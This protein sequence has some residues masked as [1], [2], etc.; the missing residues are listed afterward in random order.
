[1]GVELE[2]GHGPWESPESGTF[3]GQQRYAWY[4]SQAALARM[5][6]RRMLG[7]RCGFDSELVAAELVSNAIRHTVSG[8]R[9]GHFVVYVMLGRTPGIA[10]QDLGGSGAPRVGMRQ[11]GRFSEGGR[12]L[13]LVTRLAVRSGYWGDEREGHTVWAELRSLPFSEPMA[14]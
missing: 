12:G 1:M 13:E 10:V 2:R 7:P 5:Y 11:E 9:G 8:A 4:A 6:A 14:G 3:V